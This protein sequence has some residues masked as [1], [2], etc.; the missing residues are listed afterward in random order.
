M[1]RSSGYLA[2]S[3]LACGLLAG[4]ACRTTPPIEPLKLDGNLLVVSNQTANDWSNVEIWLNMYFRMTTSSIRSG[5]RFQAPLDA[6][7][8]GYGQRFDFKRMQV[9]D[10]RLKARL[11]DGKPIEIVKEFEVGG[12]AG[13]LK[14]MAGRSQREGDKR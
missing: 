10:L 14:G 9:K 3:A 7:I 1:I 11:P 5:G 12:L 6:F 13:A 8:S 2:R 4:A